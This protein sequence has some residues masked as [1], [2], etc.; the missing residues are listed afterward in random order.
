M[1]KRL[2]FSVYAASVALYLPCVVYGLVCWIG[3]YTAHQEPSK[4]VAETLQGIAL[5][6]VPLLLEKIFRLEIS[7]FAN[8]MLFIFSF[9]AI[10]LGQFVG[11][12]YSTSW[13][14]K[15]TH[16]FSGVMLF[17]YGTALSGVFFK[18]DNKLAVVVFGVLFALA[19][20]LLWEIA[21]FTIDTVFGSEMQKCIPDAFRNGGDIFKE[22]NGTVEEIGQFYQKPSG[23]RYALMD[24]MFDIIADTA[25]AVLSA[26]ALIFVKRE[27]CARLFGIIKR[28]PP[29]KE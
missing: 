19:A 6:F 10:F 20:G 17:F 22:L 28:K 4:I 13:W 1:E 21:E 16:V 11:L 8:L 23:Y 2:K 5:A 18:D 25:G 9:G 26:V 3:G 24:T 29:V 27:R 14:D 12:Y 7:F 15:V